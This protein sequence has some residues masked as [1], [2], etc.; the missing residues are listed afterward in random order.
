MEGQVATQE[1]QGEAEELH[2]KEEGEERRHPGTA[3]FLAVAE[4]IAG[5]TDSRR[6]SSGNRRKQHTDQPRNIE[7]TARRNRLRCQE[8]LQLQWLPGWLGYL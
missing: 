5:S 3:A 6:H 4:P 7:R 1:H 8:R 2:W